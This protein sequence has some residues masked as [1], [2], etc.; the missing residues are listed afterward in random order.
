LIEALESLVEPAA[1]EIG[2]PRLLLALRTCVRLRLPLAELLD[3]DSD[4][5]APNRL[6]ALLQP[7]WKSRCILVFFF[8]FFFWAWAD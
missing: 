3:D 4:S 2:E 8:F 7:Q 6:M 5:A 1:I